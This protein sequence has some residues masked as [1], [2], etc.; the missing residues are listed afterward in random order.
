MS[1]G[2]KAPER[3]GKALVQSL[4]ARGRDVRTGGQ[5]LTARLEPE[6]VR[7][8]LARHTRDV[9]TYLA[10]FFTTRLAAA[11]IA[12]ETYQLLDAV[13]RFTLARGERLRATLVV[14]GYT[15][16]APEPDDDRLVPAAA[17]MELLHA[18]RLVHDGDR[19]LA[20]LGRPTL[21]QQFAADLGHRFPTAEVERYGGS[22]AV[23]AGDLAAALAFDALS[24][25][26]VEPAR[27]LAAIR[28]LARVG[29][30]TGY[31][32]AMDVMAELD[33]PPDEGRLLRIHCYK[34][35]RYSVEGPLQIGAL[36][37]GAEA[38]HLDA[39]SAFA[40]PFGVACQIQDDVRRAFT[41]ED[42]A[43]TPVVGRW[44]LR[45]PNLLTVHGLR[46]PYAAQLRQILDE[47]T[48]DAATLARARRYLRDGGSVAY[49]EAR[50]A[51]LLAEATAAIARLDARPQAA[52]FLHGLIRLLMG[53]AADGASAIATTKT[54]G[55]Q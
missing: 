6:D 40:V 11:E 14:T 27:L 17:A 29:V 36:L 38:A 49:A 5:P 2:V 20:R 18:F 3:P 43:D 31:G 54:G 39:L 45:K 42:L 28:T 23:L 30:E 47:D 4:G 7:A 26:R 12:P 16:L 53:R 15:C 35:A 52:A 33:A 48:L 24:A 10:A 44:R 1:G 9:E 22:L 51:T 55:S 25:T 32:K 13:R 34:T 21:Q 41:S 50:I 46:G 19:D 8:T 37:A